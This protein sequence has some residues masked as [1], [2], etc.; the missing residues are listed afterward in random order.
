MTKTQENQTMQQPESDG[1]CCNSKKKVKSK[2]KVKKEAKP[3]CCMEL[4][5]ERENTMSRT[6]DK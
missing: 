2:V 3:S 6:A 1:C 4:D 5:V